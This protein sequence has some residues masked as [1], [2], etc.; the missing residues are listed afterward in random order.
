MRVR[1][2]TR[3]VKI[4]RLSVGSEPHQASRELVAAVAA[5]NLPE[6]IRTWVADQDGLGD[7]L[8]KGNTV[9]VRRAGAD[10]M[11]VATD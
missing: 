9:T 10:E 4:Y 2:L 7:A 8:F 1:K 3:T 6:A 11:Y 5:L